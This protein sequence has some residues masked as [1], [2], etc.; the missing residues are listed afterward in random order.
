MYMMSNR[1]PLSTLA[2]RNSA[3][4]A[5][6]A[7]T[8]VTSRTKFAQVIHFA[9]VLAFVTGGTQVCAQAIIPPSQLSQTIV[10]T[11]TSLVGRREGDGTDVALINSVLK[12]AHAQ[13]GFPDYPLPGDHVWGVYLGK[14]TRQSKGMLTTLQP[15]AYDWRPGRGLLCHPGD[16]L[17]FANVLVSSNDHRIQYS[18]GELAA[19]VI[20]V[21]P[22]GRYCRITTQVTSHKSGVMEFTIYLPNFSAG[23]IR[24][25]RPVSATTSQNTTSKNLNQKLL[26]Y[27]ID[28]LGT[29]VN[30]G[31]CAMLAQT[32]LTAIGAA[33]GFRDAPNSGDYV[34]GALVCTI[35]A[36]NGKLTISVPKGSAA[37]RQNLL[38]AIKPGDILQLSGVHIVARNPNA[39]VGED[40]THHTSIV[41]D[42]SPS[43]EVCH[44]LEQNSDGKLYVTRG[45]Y[46]LA[47]MYNGTIR[48]YQ[49]LPR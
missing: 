42:F 21:S 44:V 29:Q 39:I 11:A 4:V 9:L 14:M 32:G 16:I 40:A 30:D 24:A 27:C 47:G 46:Y 26:Q 3:Y 6:V 13:T 28:K 5:L 45:V 49:P 12:I 25:F 36:M 17:Q 23:T 19:V 37:P 48:V 33:T 35:T 18:L 43:D 2:N 8:S 20:A 1:F 22:H 10:R 7:R 38:E 31:Q 41:E 34:W 15:P